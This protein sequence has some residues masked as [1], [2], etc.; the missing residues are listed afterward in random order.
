MCTQLPEAWACSGRGLVFVQGE[1]AVLTDGR[2]GLRA[3]ELELG[4]GSDAGGVA[5]VLGEAGVA[6]G[7]LGVHA[8]AVGAGQLTDGDLVGLGSAFDADLGARS[9]VEVPVGFVGAP[10]LVANT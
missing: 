6:A 5:L 4:D 8:V 10:P 1:Q 3:R 7:L 9:E 2:R